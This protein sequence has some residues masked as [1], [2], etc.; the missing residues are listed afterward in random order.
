MSSPA[1]AYGYHGLQQWRGAT[2]VTLEKVACASAPAKTDA[3]AH[4]SHGIGVARSRAVDFR[5][6]LARTA[7]FFAKMDEHT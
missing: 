5:R 1:R 3:E 4:D 2:D 7:S 6:R